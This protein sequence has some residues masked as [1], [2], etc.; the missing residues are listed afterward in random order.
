MQH[1]TATIK[2]WYWIKSVLGPNLKKSLDTLHRPGNKIWCLKPTPFPK[3][4]FSGWMWIFYGGSSK[5]FN[6][7]D[8]IHH[9]LWSG[10]ILFVIYWPTSLLSVLWAETSMKRLDACSMSPTHRISHNICT[11][12]SN[13]P[14]RRKIYTTMVQSRKQPIKFHG[15]QA[16]LI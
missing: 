13:N 7:R 5:V 3:R 16:I 4:N 10:W 15:T 11:R 6:I 1:Y 2:L 8:Q 14:C 9:F 12:L